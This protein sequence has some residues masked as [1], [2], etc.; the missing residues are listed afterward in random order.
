MCVDLGTALM[1]GGS[2]L[3]GVGQVATAQANSKAAKYNAEVQRQNA[4]LA[5][6]QAKNVLEA[7]QREE[8]KQMAITQKLV[9]KQKA[10]FA[11]NGID[12]GFGSALDTMVDT[13]KLGEVDRLTIRTSTYRNYDDT[14]NQAVAYRN[15]GALYDMQASSSRTAGM[16]NAFGSV[17]GGLSGAASYNK[18]YGNGKLASAFGMA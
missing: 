13:V 1:I 17:L 7:G 12:V 6:K 11:A 16:L 2:V 8:Q 9:G 14:R 10:A 5:D 18:Q 4:I 3:G 15:Q